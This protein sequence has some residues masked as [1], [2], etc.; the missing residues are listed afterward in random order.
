MPDIVD[1][2]GAVAIVIFD[3]DGAGQVGCMRETWMISFKSAMLCM[4]FICP[5]C[6]IS[7]TILSDITYILIFRRRR[8]CAEIIL[9]S[10]STLS[11][12]TYENLS[13]AGLFSL[14][15]IAS[16]LPLSLYYAHN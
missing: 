9:S 16:A 10:I 5:S 7:R 3:V 6:G 8:R 2:S 13:D 12:Q 1:G 11:G 4:K 15:L 14:L